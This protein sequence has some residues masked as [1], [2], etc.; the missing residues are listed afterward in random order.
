MLKLFRRSLSAKILALLIGLTIISMVGQM[1]YATIRVREIVS[2]QNKDL[3]DLICRLASSYLTDAD[4]ENLTEEEIQGYAYQ[5]MAIRDCEGVQFINIFRTE[6]PFEEGC[7]IITAGLNDEVSYDLGHD[8]STWKPL[9]SFETEAIETQDTV[10]SRITGKYDGY[11]AIYPIWN[12]N[13]GIIGLAEVFINYET[14]AAHSLQL[15]NELILISEIFH[16]ALMVLFILILR[17]MILKPIRETS[18]RMTHFVRGDQ[19]STEKLTVRGEDEL[20]RMRGAFNTMSDDIGNYIENVSA[21]TAEKEQTRAENKAAFEI[22]LGMQPPAAFD[23]GLFHIRAFMK[24]SREV[25]GDLYDYF[26]IDDHRFCFVIA[27]VSGKGMSA[28][29]MSSA[30]IMAIRYNIRIY[31]DPAQAMRAVNA[32]LCE[33]NPENLFVTAFAAVYDEGTGLLTYANAGHNPP[34]LLG[35]KGEDGRRPLK[36]LDDKSGLVLGLF[37]DETYVET[38][39]PVESGSGLFLYTDGVTEAVDPDKT[40]F[41][42]ERLEEVLRTADDPVSEVRSALAA[43]TGEAVQH[44]DITMQ[45]VIFEK[46]WDLTLPARLSELDRLKACFLENVMIPETLRKKLYLAVEEVFVNVVS[47]AYEGKEGQVGLSLTICEDLMTLVIRDKG[48]PFDPLQDVVDPDDYDPD[49]EIGG[50]GRLMVLTIMDEASYAYENEENILT[51]K[52]KLEG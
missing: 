16:A 25:G 50:L 1:I 4:F 45:A 52:K 34:Y 22:Q 7:D 49:L 46:V 51:L 13:G 30:A 17:R 11:V 27:D 9:K 20:A 23:D 19:L 36:V 24:P 47:Y 12:H 10:Y 28:A 38:A 41:G 26:R 18:S 3:G 42:E 21:L 15:F 6:D 14:V 31:G 8:H 44:D 33:R 37:D 5:I 43:F 35:L 29:L 2:N 39:L 48:V 32:E 40:F